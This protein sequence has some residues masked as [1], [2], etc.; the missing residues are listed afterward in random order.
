MLTEAAQRPTLWRHRPSAHRT[1]GSCRCSKTGSHILEKILQKLADD[2]PTA[3]AA[4]QAAVKQVGSASV[5]IQNDIWQS[6]FF[7]ESA[8][9]E[10]PVSWL[11]VVYVI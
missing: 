3:D 8:L 4:T 7:C 9:I 1:V 2:A 6:A 10:T 5:S 11:S